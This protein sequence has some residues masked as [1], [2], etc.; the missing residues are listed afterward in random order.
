MRALGFALLG[1]LTLC[2]AS[3]RL[4]AGQPPAAKSHEGKGAPES[5]YVALI[6]DGIKGEIE[7]SF[8][9]G[10]E[11][12]LLHLTNLLKEGKI[13]ELRIDKPA[14]IFDLSWELGLWTAVVFVLLLIILRKLAWK[15]MLEGLQK[16]ENNIKSALEEARRSNEE[17]QK[18]RA[19][20]AAQM[21]GAEQKVKAVLDGARRDAQRVADE[22]VNKA[23]GEILA[24][25]QRLHSEVEIARDQALE[26]ISVRTAE[27]ATLVAGK[28]LG[29]KIELGDQHRLIEESIA[30]LA[31]GRKREQVSA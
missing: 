29:R 3:A 25:R 7:E 13:Q 16:R 2:A 5:K 26:Q 28:A 6:E 15:P 24:D 12:D 23:K 30:E 19:E 8:D 31:Q 18:L 9:L 21:A 10:Q 27:L 4:T 17:S 22:M 14:N 20:M 11:K 1:A